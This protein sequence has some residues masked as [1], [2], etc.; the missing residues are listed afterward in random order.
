MDWFLYEKDLRHERVNIS[1]LP[2]YLMFYIYINLVKLCNPEV[3]L[4][5]AAL[6][7]FAIFTGKYLCWSLFLTTMQAFLGKPFSQ[8]TSGRQVLTA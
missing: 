7:N 6:K 5:K 2:L 1:F 4:E 3:F 8:N